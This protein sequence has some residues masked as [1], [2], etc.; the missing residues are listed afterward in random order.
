MFTGAGFPDPG[1]AER[2]PVEFPSQGIGLGAGREKDPLQ[3]GGNIRV[4]RNRHALGW[5]SNS[6]TCGPGSRLD[7][8]LLG[9]GQEPFGLPSFVFPMDLPLNQSRRRIRRPRGEV[10]MQSGDHF[11]PDRGGSGDT[12]DIPLRAARKIP[13]PH[14]HCKARS[15]PDT[16][17][18]A[19]VLAGSGLYGAPETS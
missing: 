11:R 18:V 3:M 19:Y 12:A 14:A 5:I 9:A 6:I 15:E 17:V 16:P 2:L 13:N 10:L 7:S 4:E 8:V 1:L